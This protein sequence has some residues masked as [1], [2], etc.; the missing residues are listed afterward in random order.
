MVP[1]Q[2]NFDR[3]FLM[4]FDFLWLLVNSVCFLKFWGNHKKS[5]IYIAE[6]SQDE[7]RL[8]FWRNCSVVWKYIS[9]SFRR[10]R[11][12]FFSKFNF[13]N[14]NSCR[15][16]E[17][18]GLNPFLPKNVHVFL[19]GIKCP[20]LMNKLTSS[21]RISFPLRVRRAWRGQAA[22][23]EASQG[24]EKSKIATGIHLV[25]TNYNWITRSKEWRCV[26]HV[27][28][29]SPKMHVERRM[30]RTVFS[31]GNLDVDAFLLALI[32]LKERFSNFVYYQ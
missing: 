24:T 29:D 10:Q 19:N 17:R 11:N 31:K 20:H 30:F 18:D 28:C 14:F 15:L 16:M 7:R 1:W 12:H 8:R 21:L 3:L 27:A 25:T 9:F 4:I 32:L 22:S 2:P 6:P 13:Y 23:F 5:K 26:S